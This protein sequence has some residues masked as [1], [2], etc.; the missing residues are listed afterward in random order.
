MLRRRGN[1]D[2]M[3]LVLTETSTRNPK[4]EKILTTL[5]ELRIVRQNWSGAQDVA[6]QLLKINPN[7]GV[8]QNIVAAIQLGQKKFVQ[9]VETLKLATESLANPN[10]S[11]MV[12]RVKAHLGA[13]Q[14]MEAENFLQSVLDV[15]PKNIDALIL[16]GNVKR[17]QRK[18]SESESI[19]RRVIE[20]DPKA[21]VGYFSLAQMLANEKRTEEAEQ[22]LLLGRKSANPD[23]GAS[24]LL[25]SI[26]ELR[27]AYD[28]AIKIY[29]EQLKLTPDVLVVVNNLTSLLADYRSDPESTERAQALVKRL[30]GVDVPQFQDTVGWLAY[31]RGDLRTALSSLQIAV[32]KLPEQAVVRYHY[33]MTLIGLRRPD[34][35][36]REFEAANK[37]IGPDDPLNAKIAAAIAKAASTAATP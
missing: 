7:S 18:S 24:L 20:M 10:A 30:N 4:E 33:G 19:Y 26:L 1:F 21:S 23:L 22:V 27:G 5:A 32:Q 29:E 9:S 11:L 28:E 3:E 17:A 25:A 15:N 16:L 31:L 37:L 12:A 2:A 34:D 35:A 36:K 13:N 14:P 6:S 8:A